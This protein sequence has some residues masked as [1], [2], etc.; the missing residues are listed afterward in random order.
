MTHKDNDSKGM[1]ET[2]TRS[3]ERPI[4]TPD[5]DKLERGGFIARLC[6]AVIERQ[7]KKATG[8]IIGITG[9]WGSGKSSILNLLDHHIKLDYPD[10]IV[11]RFDPWLISGR[12]DL[13]SEFYGADR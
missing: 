13:I 7:T 12:N 10:A 8:A 9:Q 5:Q 3:T 6:N 4:D 11:I 1:N 2:P